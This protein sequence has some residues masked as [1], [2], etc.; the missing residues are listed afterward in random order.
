MFVYI[1]AVVNTETRS[2][3]SLHTK[4]FTSAP[5]TA[6]INE[7]HRAEMSA[8]LLKFLSRFKSVF[9]LSSN[10]YGRVPLVWRGVSKC[11]SFEVRELIPRG[12]LRVH[13]GPKN[14]VQTWTQPE[15]VM[16]R[17]VRCL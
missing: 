4:L 13:C 8:F 15:L 14:R 5:L 16:R 10:L 9:R 3:V 2:S 17:N 12:F 11:W 6:H 7:L 1:A